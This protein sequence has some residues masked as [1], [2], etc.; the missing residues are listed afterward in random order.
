MLIIP[1]ID[2]KG[3]KVVRLTQGDPWLA[4]IYADDPI[5][6]ALEWRKAGAKRLHVVDL[7]GAFEGTPRHREIIRQIAEA[8]D[9]PVQAGGGL[10]ALE[11]I[12]DLLQHR[13]AFAVLGTSAILNHTFLEEACIRYPRRIILAV[14]AKDGK[15]MV[16]GWAEATSH[17]AV[18]LVQAVGSIPLAAIIYTD[19]RQDGT[20]EGPNLPGLKAI[21]EVSRH[22]VI[23]S[24]GIASLQDVKQVAS[25][26]GVMGM[27]VG[28]AL[29]SGALALDEATQEAV[30]ASRERDAGGRDV[31]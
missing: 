13:V 28:K 6:V 12:D 27:L 22:P 2:L 1:A 5:A 3:G 16:K 20:L 9:I 29:Y 23:A 7:D 15:V 30:K 10:R 4:T 24:G 21:A 14:D 31:S 26:R 8:V 18:K 11:A 17:S 25:I 19:V